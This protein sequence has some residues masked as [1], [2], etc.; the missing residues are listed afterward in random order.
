MER[1]SRARAQAQLQELQAAKDELQGTTTKLLNAQRQAHDLPIVA[2]EL[3]ELRLSEEAQRKHL[4]QLQSEL[5]GAKKE[6]EAVVGKL[7][8]SE[9]E[10]RAVERKKGSARKA[11]FD[12]MEQLSATLV[13]E[14]NAA[15]VPSRLSHLLRSRM[16]IPRQPPLRPTPG[17]ALHLSLVLA[18]YGGGHPPCLR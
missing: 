11:E 8:F 3:D 17:A 1:E 5:R 9:Q 16:P 15:L 13:S 14:A 6:L 7:K 4:E 12:S 10:K 18:E 2:K